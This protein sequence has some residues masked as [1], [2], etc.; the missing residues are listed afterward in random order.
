M[1]CPVLMNHARST[2][3][4][5]LKYPSSK[6]AISWQEHKILWP[7]LQQLLST[8]Q[9][10]NPQNYA[11]LWK[12]QIYN[13]ANVKAPFCSRTHCTID[14]DVDCCHCPEFISKYECRT[15]YRETGVIDFGLNWSNEQSDSYSDVYLVTAMLYVLLWHMF[16]LNSLVYVKCL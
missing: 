8:N 6:F 14:A 4:P 11:Y 10:I 1:Y 2:G 15:C 13:I 3:W 7:I 12:R 9:W 16:C 5:K